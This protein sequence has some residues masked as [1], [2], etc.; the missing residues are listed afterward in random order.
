MAPAAQTTSEAEIL[1][2]LRTLPGIDVDHGLR[3]LHGKTGRYISLLRNLLQSQGS[4]WTA[5]D[6]CL[7]TGDCTAAKRQIHSLKGATGTLALTELATL[8][9]HLDSLLGD[10]GGTLAHVETVR[11]LLDE[12]RAEMKILENALSA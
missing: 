6:R 4:D 12:I 1:Q 10:A 7:A 9:T 11:A 2:R 8:A 3:L 5:L